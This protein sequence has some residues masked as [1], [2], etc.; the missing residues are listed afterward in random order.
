[1]FK[2]RFL[3]I[4]LHIIMWIGYTALPLL[5]AFQND[6]T[7]SRVNP[8]TN[9]TYWLYVSITSIILFYIN[10]EVLFPKIYKK[11]PIRYFLSLI[12][13]ILV[14][15]W[16]R[17]FVRITFVG[18]DINKSLFYVNAFIQ[19]LYVF[20][21][22]ASYCFFSDY[23]KQQ[24]IQRENEN[25]RLKSE[26]SFLRSQISPHFMF[27]LMNSL[28]SLNRKKSNLVEP[29]LLKMADLLRYMLY[30][31]DDKRISLENEVKYLSNYIDLQKVRFGDYV[32]I[33]F[34]VNASD[35]SKSIEP[36]L[37]I[38]FVEN[39]FKHGVGLIENPFIKIEL[40][41]NTEELRFKVTNKF[42]SDSK[43][44]KDG[45]SGIGLNNVKRR[46]ELLY[47]NK[48]VLDVSESENLYTTNLK[49]NFK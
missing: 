16:G 8:Y 46:L 36:M 33:D 4:F 42:S 47:P 38:P 5:N 3:Y 45:A 7:R 24:E 26:L 31:K 17:F 15:L 21:I 12:A 18:N 34:D 41:T 44:V 1:M 28:V 29:V 20:G 43:E 19:Y 32:K 11:Q 13:V 48:Y 49:L 23:Q 39:A 40:E 10:S 37:L 27:N 2:N 14:L 35:S 9:T 30:E 6:S 22:S 25:E